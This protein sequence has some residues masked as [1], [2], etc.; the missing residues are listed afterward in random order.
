[1][2]LSRPPHPMLRSLIEVI[3]AAPARPGTG[4]IRREAVLPTGQC[5]LAIRIGGAPF[6]IAEPA[7]S[8]A[9]QTLSNAVIGGP[10]SGRYVKFLDG[11]GPNV[12]ALL[13]PGAT[14]LLFGVP[15][16]DL[17]ERHIPLQD[18]WGSSATARLVD[19][20]AACTGETARLASFEA[21]LMQ[22]LTP[23]PIGLHPAIAQTLDALLPD[24]RIGL[25]RAASGLNRKR[26]DSLFR[27]SVGLT[28]KRYQRLIRFRAALARL[29]E[30]E[31]ADLA[32][33]AYAAG[34]SD[35]A[36]FQHEFRA[37]AGITPGAYRRLGP[38]AAHHLPMPD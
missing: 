4:R 11:G 30:G 6:R 23:R 13:R 3:W 33:I 36:H 14:P 17:A 31:Q 20:L 2:P 22:R 12:G 27:D 1:M 25:L 34:F 29:A 37:I 18:V 15:A 35:Q 21:F 16:S 7:D 28:P 9:P 32:D 8:T 26:F 10:R 24:A 5:H 38:A 19:R